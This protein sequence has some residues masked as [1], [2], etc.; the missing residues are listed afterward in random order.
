MVTQAEFDARTQE[1]RGDPE[2]KA[3]YA[4]MRLAYEIG[5]AV[6]IAREVLGWT[7]TYLAERAGMKQHALSR[8]ESG[9]VLP[10]LET[11]HRIATALDSRFEMADD[12]SGV[13]HA[14]FVTA[15]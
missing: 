4:R 14:A 8:V 7:Q 13:P 6:R 12:G 15:A 10:T 1:Q 2:Y 9:D 3:E 11:V 5:A